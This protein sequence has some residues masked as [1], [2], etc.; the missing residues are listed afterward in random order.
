MKSNGRAIV[1]SGARNQN[2]LLSRLRNQNRNTMLKAHAG[3]SWMESMGNGV[4][5][6]RDTLAKGS[7]SMEGDINVGCDRTGCE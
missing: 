7:R 4:T 2:M 5:D 1:V 6:R 3:N